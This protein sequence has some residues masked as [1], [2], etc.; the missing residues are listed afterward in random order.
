M[1]DTKLGTTGLAIHEDRYPMIYRGQVMNNLDLTK[2]GR[3]QIK[4]HPM[5]S[6]ITDITLL[7][8]A[9]PAFPLWEGA[10]TNSGFFA[11]PK[12]GSWVFVFFEQGD[13]YQPVY[14]AEA[15]TATLGLPSERLENY[16]NNKVIKS[17]SGI[18]I[19]V[20]DITGVIQ[21]KNKL[22]ANVTITKTGGVTIE[23][24]KD[25]ILLNSARII[26][27]CNEKVSTGITGQFTTN[28]NNV[29]TVSD[30]IVTEIT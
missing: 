24:V 30:G 7:P 10:G 29:I 20:N 3:I 4:V 23:G 14:F 26:L 2:A 16:P 15:P 27:N 28:T 19:L 18:V 25:D 21:L 1:A 9:V 13:V 12:I 6:G 8:W 22:G 5:F 11:V 17:A